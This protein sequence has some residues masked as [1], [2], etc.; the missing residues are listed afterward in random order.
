MCVCVCTSGS[1][2]AC[3]H[4]YLAGM[5]SCNFQDMYSEYIR[6]SNLGCE[7]AV[8]T[9]VRTFSQSS[10]TEAEQYL[11]AFGTSSYKIHASESSQLIQHCVTAAWRALVST[12]MN[13]RVP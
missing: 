3:M 11:Q 4:V 1:A 2:F 9:H 13:F 8:L 12:V 7:S 6:H 10:K 5:R